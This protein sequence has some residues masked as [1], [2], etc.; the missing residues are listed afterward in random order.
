ME[1]PVILDPRVLQDLLD[2]QVTLDYQELR[3]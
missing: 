1:V 2:L 3:V